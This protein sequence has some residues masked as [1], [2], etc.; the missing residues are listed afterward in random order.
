VDGFIFLIFLL[1]FVF[2]FLK[3]LNKSSKKP[4]RKYR[5]VS[6][7]VSGWGMENGQVRQQQHKQSHKNVSSDV[8]PEDHDDRVRARDQ[9]ARR[10]Y[11]KMEKNI[12]SKQNNAMTRI[13]NKSRNDWGS[14]GE[15][16]ITSS[17]AVIIF[18]LLI[19]LAH[20]IVAAFAPDLIPGN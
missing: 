8:F 15:S 3:R 16:G 5:N 4:T 2:P 20:F 7:K 13:S 12:H 11:L 14:K 10:E 9:H 6:K 18:L 1:F 19:L 17:K